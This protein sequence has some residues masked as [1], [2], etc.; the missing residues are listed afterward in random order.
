MRTGIFPGE[1]L[2]SPY[3]TETQGSRGILN[4]GYQW[5]RENPTVKDPYRIDTND[6]LHVRNNGNNKS[7]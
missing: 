5:D 4:E 6:V 3:D 7:I 1:Y 2:V